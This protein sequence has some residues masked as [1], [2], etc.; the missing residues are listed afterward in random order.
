MKK[1]LLLLSVVISGCG[2]GGSEPSI[3]STPATVSPAAQAALIAPYTSLLSTTPILLPDLKVK[4]DAMCGKNVSVQTAIP[5][6][7]NNDGK[8]DLVF[9]LW[10][11]PTPVGSAYIGPPL[12]TLVAIIQTSPGV[13]EDKTKDIFGSDIVDLGGKNYGY[14]TTDLNGDGYEDLVMSCDRE[15]TRIP[16]DVAASNMKCQTVSF[17]SD[18]KGHYNKLTFGNTLWGDD[19]K[20]I[21]DKNGNKQIILLPADT[22]PEVWAFNGQWNRVTVFDWMQK[23]PVFI[24][25]ANSSDPT[26]IIN[27]YDNGRKLEIWNIVNNTWSKLLDY[28]YLVST[29]ILLPNSTQGTATTSIFKVDNTDYIDYGGV[30]EGCALKRTKDGPTEVLYSF[31]GGLIEGGYTG[32]TL[33][34]TG[35]KPKVVKLMSL[36]VTTQ[37]LN[38]SPVTLNTD[39]IDSSFYHMHCMDFNNDGLDDIIVRTTGTPLIYVNNGQGK[40]GKLNSNTIPKAPAGASHI[41]ID[42]DGDGIKDLLY[43]PINGWQFG[44]YTKVQFLLHKGNRAIKQDDLVFA[45]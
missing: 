34:N 30:Y 8:T 13:F 22:A 17:I 15:D 33:T 43:F 19:I 27:K 39:Q 32:Q 11:P 1:L 21:K 37:N 41:Y 4:Y 24:Q 3:V 9:T 5:I 42:I 31:V 28:F 18:G 12:N 16:A 10:C 44:S 25:S 38:I 35:S 7:L 20:L 6:D 14:I 40:F 2:G 36:G 23:N 29:T 26:I 45:N